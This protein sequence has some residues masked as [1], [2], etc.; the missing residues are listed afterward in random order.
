MMTHQTNRPYSSATLLSWLARNR[1]TPQGVIGFI[2]LVMTTGSWIATP[3]YAGTTGDRLLLAQQV[4]DGLPPPPP[5][6][7]EQPAQQPVQ[8]LNSPPAGTPLVPRVDTPAQASPQQRYLVYVNGDS[9]LLLAQVRK[10]ESGAFLQ[11]YQ[12]RQVIQAGLFS[13]QTSAERQAATLASQGIVAEV[14]PISG[15]ELTAASGQS[16]PQTV[17]IATPSPDLIPVTQVPRE[18]E[19]GQPAQISQAGTQPFESAAL[20]DNSYYVAIPERASNIESVSNQVRRLGG[21]LGIGQVTNER[22][23][24]RGTHVLVGPFTSRGTAARWSRYFRDFGL[25]ARVYYRR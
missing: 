16:A 7:F 11:T 25:D 21:G 10:V 3:A 19:F 17:N 2:S 20:P 18:I 13:E 14:I 23:A 4:I 8:P 1:F 22:S 24:P 6:I 9:P 5:L 15:S 12:E